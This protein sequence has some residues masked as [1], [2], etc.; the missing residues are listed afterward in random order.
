MAV[1]FVNAAHWREPGAG[2]AADFWRGKLDP[3]YIRRYTRTLEDFGF[4]YTLVAYHS[5]GPDQYVR[6]AEILTYTERLKPM[7]AVRPNTSFPTVAAQALSTLDQLGKGRTAVHIISGSSNEE[8]Q[9]QGDYLEKDARYRRSAEFVQI[10]RD[11]WTKTE[12]FSHHGEFYDFDDFGPGYQTYSGEP[13]PVSL[14]GSSDY[15]YAAGGA[16]ADIFALWGEPLEQTKQQIDRVYEEARKVGRTGKIRFWVTFRPI[17]AETDELA[18]RKA[19]RLVEQSKAHYGE[20]LKVNLPNVGSQRLRDIAQ[21]GETH[22]GGVLWTP[23]SIAGAGG[24]S[25]FLVGSPETIAEALVRY[26]ELG[27]EVISLPTLGNIGDAIDTGR[28]IIPLV[29]EELARREVREKVAT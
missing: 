8:Q 15:A 17:V 23:R 13:I 14:G 5:A 25:S 6:S 24:A 12:P 11:V 7:V 2:L 21:E 3:E 18:Q 29:R 1:E 10:L 27:A 22:D 16:Q 4:D 9:R 26:A 28:Y 20:V 19:R